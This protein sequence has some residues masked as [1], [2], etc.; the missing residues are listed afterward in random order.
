M[1]IVLA[2]PAGDRSV[3]GIRDYSQ[4]LVEQL[5]A[6]GDDATLIRPRC[7]RALAALLDRSLPPARPA[8]AL[9]QYNPFA[10][11]RW[12]FAPG[13]LA[14]LALMRLLR[15]RVRV[16]VAV[17]EA[18]VPLRGLKWTLMGAWQRAQ[19]RLALA[20]AHGGV[21]MEEWLSNELSYRLPRRPMF[22]VPVGSNL[23]DERGARDAA[24][25]D[26]G[27][28]G[29]LVVATL[30]TGHDTQLI[31][32]VA[33]AATAAATASPRPVTVLV[34]GEGACA[35]AAIAGVES[36][37]VAG[38]LDQRSLA[39]AI[40]AAD[41]FLVPFAD[42]ASTRRTSLMAALQHAVATVSTCG[43]STDGIFSDAGAP[44]LVDVG[45][46]EGFAQQT[47]RVAANPTLRE[48]VASAGHELYLARFSWPVICAGIR[49]AIAGPEAGA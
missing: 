11:G 18:Y 29:H 27:L 25:H 28:A 12:G 46:A 40:A 23:P 26:L 8:A 21:A 30:A 10:W 49:A 6:E 32:Y 20:L 34:L 36:V 15:R 4:R 17:H 39:R 1:K 5:C 42:G 22:H 35:P 48:Q 37:L 13:F 44:L 2:Y 41:V 24:R 14:S 7:G 33:E 47:A 3:D 19:L 45:D 43:S 9:I 16:L 31:K 38:Y